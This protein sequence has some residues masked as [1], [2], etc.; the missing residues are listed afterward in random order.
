MS[1]SSALTTLLELAQTRTDDAAKRL[2][3]LQTQGVH[4]EAKLQLL[5]QY[6]DDYCARFQALMQQGLTA[7]DWRNYQEFLDKL[8]DAITQQREAL[9]SAHQRVAA[10]R[11]AWQSAKRTFN[12]YDT[13]AQRDMRAELLRTVKREQQETDEYAGNTTARQKM[14]R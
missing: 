9:A 1:K 4:M 7:S 10:G 5:L 13:L 8:D 2:G 12:S 3:A 11:A 6:R 14:S